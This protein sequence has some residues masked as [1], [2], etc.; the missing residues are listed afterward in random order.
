M[1][2][3]KV[4]HQGEGGI[5]DLPPPGDARREELLR[6]ADELEQEAAAVTAELN[7]ISPKALKVENEVAQHVVGEFNELSVPNAD[8]NYSYCWVYNDPTRRLGNR[9]IMAKKSEGWEVVYHDDEDAKGMAHCRHVDGSIVI[10]DVTLMRIDVGRFLALERKRRARQRAAETGVTS[11]L[12]EMADKYAGRGVK[13]M[14]PEN[15]PP[16]YLKRMAGS[17]AAHRLANERFEKMIRTG[18]VPG[19]PVK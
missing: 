6:R 11:E 16:D 14:T 18:N 2:D 8:P 17:Q 3:K 4:L 7:A 9:W 19:A 1:A 12:Q 5:D 10:G 15:L 13:V